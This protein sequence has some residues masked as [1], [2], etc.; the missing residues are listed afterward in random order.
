MLECCTMGVFDTSIRKAL[1]AVS[2]AGIYVPYVNFVGV[3]TADAGRQ[4]VGE[5]WECLGSIIP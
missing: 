3:C 4:L 2:I 1:L 5:R